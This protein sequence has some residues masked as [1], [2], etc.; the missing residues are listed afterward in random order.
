MKTALV[1][2][3][4]LDLRRRLIGALHGFTVFEAGDDGEALR[5]LQFIEIDL[6]ARDGR[7]PEGAIPAFVAQVKRLAPL[8]LTIG[9]GARREDDEQ[10]TDFSLAEGFSP[11]D[12]ENVLRQALQ[13]RQLAHELAVLRAPAGGPEPDR[14]PRWDEATFA[15]VLKGFTRLFAAGFDLPRVLDMFID[16]VSELVRPARIAILMADETGDFAVVADRGLAPQVVQAVRLSPAEGLVRWLA[17]QG[18]PARLQDVQDL[19]VARE[20]KL[21]QGVVAVPLLARGQLVAVLVVGPPVLGPGYAPAELETLFDLATHL[22]TVIRDVGLHHELAHEKEFT[23]R[24]LFHMSS[25]VITIGRD[26]RVG[27][28]NRRAAEILDLTEGAVVGQDL[29]VLPSPLGDMLYEALSTGRGVTRT[30]I[31]LPLRRLW[32]EVSTYVVRDE[33]GAP[34][35]AVLVFEDLTAQKELAA[36]KRQAEQLQLLGRVVARIAD[37]IKNPLVSVSTFVELIGERYDDPDFR[38]HFSMVVHRDVRRLVE[39]FEKL[40]SLVTGG[41]L[42]FS[43]VDA[44]E[45]VSQLVEIV[46]ASDEGIER[47]LQLDVS[48]ATEPLLVR[49]DTAQLRRALQYL[50]RFLAHNSAGEQARVSVSVGAHDGG[51]G[52][53]EVRILVAS[54]TASVPPDKVDCIFD[55]VHMVQESLIDVGPAVSQRLIEALGGRLAMRQGKHELAFLV[56]L[57]SVTP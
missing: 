34:M 54:R 16:A 33:R 21:V 36:Q 32:L 22:A 3:P 28:L 4:D 38:K 23:D 43:T 45:V 13:R 19:E 50:V 26:E 37:E 51:A 7:A 24:I 1:V 35:G 56:S 49:V 14:A 46:D 17:A 10:A 29:R 5:M 52:V 31:Q 2:T 53:R 39:V 55:P 44:Y 25:G 20:L 48:P 8:A 9:V 47:Q 6:V 12:A 15:R 11:R 57:P 40:V 18:R 27:T 41:R 30:E 42:N